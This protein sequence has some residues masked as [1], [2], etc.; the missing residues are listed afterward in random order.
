MYDEDDVPQN[1]IPEDDSSEEDADALS[2][3]ALSAAYAQLLNGGMP[4]AADSNETQ[5]TPHP[6]PSEEQELE[7]EAD[8]QSG[9][10]PLAILEA[11]L[12]VGSPDNEPLTSAQVASLMRGVGV[13]E[14]A[15]MIMTLNQTYSD[16]QRPYR[17]ESI[18][19]G[20]AL[21][22]RDEYA[23]LRDKFYGRVREAR[24]SQAAV[25]VLA[26]VAYQQPLARDD[27]DRLRGRPSGAVLN[28]LVRRQLIR[29]ERPTD[30]PRRP[31]YFTTDRFLALFGMES[32]GELP[33]SHDL[34]RDF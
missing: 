16:D 11:I 2:L 23:G 19:A 12:F 8:D 26:I 15:E 17:V 27:V 21:Q 3:E 9:V 22:L 20:Y 5:G 13:S 10:T 4:Q 30:K 1:G 34:D 24:L 14:V 28:Q 31:I 6:G 33:E 18:G 29:I 25:D 7:D 32:L